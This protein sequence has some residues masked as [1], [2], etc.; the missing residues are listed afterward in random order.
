MFQ[1]QGIFCPLHSDH[2]V[3]VTPQL[4]HLLFFLLN[5]FPV[6]CSDLVEF[7]STFKYMYGEQYLH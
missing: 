7:Q 1:A 3:L 4:P 6:S 5:L 2:V